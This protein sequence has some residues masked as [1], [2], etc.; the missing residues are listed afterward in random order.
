MIIYTFCESAGASGISAWHIRQLSKQG[1][2]LGG[3]ADTLSLCGKKM[4]WD[5]GN[6]K[7]TDFHVRHNCCEKC[8]KEFHLI[9]P[10]VLPWNIKDPF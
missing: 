9:F 3:G 2:K 5:L 8:S 4:C 7:M 6:I 1:L 10:T